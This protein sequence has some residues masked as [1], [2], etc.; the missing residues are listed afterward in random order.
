[1]E[2]KDVA[3]WLLEKGYA[4]DMKGKLSF[5]PH[6]H[7]AYANIRNSV[8]M[9]VAIVNWGTPE[10]TVLY[11]ANKVALYKYE[12]WSMMYMQFIREAKV[13]NR[14]VNSHGEPYDINKYSEDGMK[15]FQKALKTGA[16][17]DILVKSTMLAYKSGSRYKKTIGN[18]MSQGDWRSDYNT[19][20]EKAQ[21]GEQEVTNHI[22]DE[23]NDG[24]VSR[25]QRG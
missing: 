21:Q 12:D 4:I 9:E 15:A 23:L 16:L 20:L 7:K 13:P 17:Y 8:T 11:D 25:Y 6:F 5:T 18:Y 19:L 14:C 24:T 10:M 3:Q 1:M 2:L 22:K